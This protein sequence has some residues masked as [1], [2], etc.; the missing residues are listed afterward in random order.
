MT[1]QIA[2]VLAALIFPSIATA[3]PLFPQQA[4]QNNSFF[5]PSA[6]PTNTSG[7]CHSGTGGD[8]NWNSP[9]TTTSSPVGPT[10][11][12]V[13]NEIAGSTPNDICFLGGPIYARIW[14]ES[15]IITFDTGAELNGMFD[16]TQVS[17][18]W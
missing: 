9:P 10:D 8:S 18:F 5:G 17:F 3:A 13:L 11:G 7:T 14:C 6:N 2:I 16:T 12:G 15:P 4:P 1:R